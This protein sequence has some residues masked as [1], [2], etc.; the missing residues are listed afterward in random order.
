MRIALSLDLDL[1]KFDQS[2]LHILMVR[3]LQLQGKRQGF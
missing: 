1:T 3:W 2:R